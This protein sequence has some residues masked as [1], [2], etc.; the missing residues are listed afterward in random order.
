MPEG[1]RDP[2]YPATLS[3]WGRP[4]PLASAG[5]WLLERAVPGSDARDATGPYPLFACRDWRALGDDLDA[6]E[7][8]LVTVTAIT[9]PFADTTEAELR[10]AFRTLVRPYRHHYVIDLAPG[11]PRSWSHHTEHTARR[12]LRTLD[13]ELVADPTT[14]ALT[15]TELYGCLVS[16]H[17]ITGMRAF[18]LASFTRLLAMPG[19]SL[20]LARHEGHV[21][22]GQVYLRQDDVIHCHLG[23][24]T[25]EAYALGAFHAMDRHSVDL[26]R[27]S[28]AWLDLGGGQSDDDSDGLSRYKH[29]W[30]SLTRQTWLCG[31]ILDPATYTALTGA[32]SDP[33][34]GW[35]PAYRAGTG[36]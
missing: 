1:Y 29:R 4:V 22:A 5:G 28:A 20:L 16:R 18:S 31:R 3:A 11:A 2:A 8:R 13:L 9:D 21:V 25:P 15:W 14:H 36:V 7:G 33:A 27:G 24:A 10:A 30:T 32:P 26:F 17:G 6:L 12:A 19:V 23:A 34:G 35:F